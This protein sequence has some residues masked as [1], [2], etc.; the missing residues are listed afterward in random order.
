M[1]KKVIIMIIDALRWDFITG[2]IG[3]IAMPV[4]NN[5]IEN[6]SASLLKTKVHSPTVTMP[7]IK[8]LDF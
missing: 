5:L 4:T 1:V 2:S 3:K 8:V 7:R 6:S